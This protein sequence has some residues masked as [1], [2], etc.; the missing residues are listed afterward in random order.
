MTAESQAPAYAAVVFGAHPDDAEMA[1]G[2]TIAKLVKAGHRSLI[3]S[4]TRGEGGT[5]G[6]VA[7]RAREA[8]AAAA[9]LGCDCRLL[10]FPD[11]RVECT[12]ESRE[13]IVDV[14]RETRPRIVFAPFPDSTLG[15]RD[16]AAHVDHI[17]TGNIVRDAVKL[18]RLRGLAR[19]H[20]AH[21]VWR[22]YYY[23]VPRNVYPHLAVDVTAELDTLVRAISAYRTQMEIARHGRPI[24]DVLRVYRASLGAVIGCEYAEAF[25]SDQTLRAGVDLLFEL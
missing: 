24:L 9:V 17:A 7:S 18:A 2:G 25:T 14:L 16:G 12:V 23:M 5:F 13:R 6:D 22:L 4:L 8:A 21:E 15:H 11:T 19:P 1:M 20:P 3:V 10:D